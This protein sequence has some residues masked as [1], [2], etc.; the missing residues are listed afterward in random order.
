MDLIRSLPGGEHDPQDE[1][2]GRYLVA[3][4]NAG[5]LTFAIETQG[6]GKVISSELVVP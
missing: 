3:T 6:Y 1:G 2:H 4:T 5:F